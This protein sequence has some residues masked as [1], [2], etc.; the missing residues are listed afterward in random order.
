MALSLS[1]KGGLCH[2]SGN[3]IDC[4]CLIH[5]LHTSYITKNSSFIIVFKSTLGKGIT[6]KGKKLNPRRLKKT[7]TGSDTIE[8]SRQAF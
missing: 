2:S 3:I 8:S 6:K 5:N 7:V 4:L 1:Q